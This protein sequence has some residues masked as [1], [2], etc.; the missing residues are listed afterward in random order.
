[1]KEFVTN[2]LGFDVDA[3]L[4]T[5][6]WLTFPAQKLLSI[7]SGRIYE[8]CPTKEST[9]PTS[10]LDAIREKLAYY[11]RDIWLYIMA[12]YWQRI[13]NEGHLMCR[14]GVVGDELGAAVIAARL[15]RD[16][17]HICFLLSRE[18]APYTKWFGSAFKRLPLVKETALEGL[19]VQVMSA[20]DWTV[21]H[22]RLNQ[23]YELICQLHNE[24]SFNITPGDL[25][26]THVIPFHDRPFNVIS[27][28]D[29]SSTLRKHI[30]DPLLTE[31]SKKEAACRPLLRNIDAFC[32]CCALTEDTASR[33]VLVKLYDMYECKTVTD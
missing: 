11:P 22:D 20:Q 17:M 27:L 32:D 8:R 4:T 26:Q 1:M 10:P 29:I 15:V 7:T 31:P 18:Y 14:C 2:Q 12:S 9:E 30:V 23:V 25:L 5:A 3:P 16:I 13:E 28:G 33:G 19:L 6:D 24:S 21:R